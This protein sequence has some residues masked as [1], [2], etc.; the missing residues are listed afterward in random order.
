MWQNLVA[1]L[2]LGLSSFMMLL[3]ETLDNIGRVLTL[4][5]S[6]RFV[7]GKILRV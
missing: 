6:Y 5:K 3:M 7:M 2:N 4:S 1:K